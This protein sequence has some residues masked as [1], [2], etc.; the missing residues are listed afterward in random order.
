MVSFDLVIVGLANRVSHTQQ[1]A[2]TWTKDDLVTT[3][4]LGRIF[5]DVWNKDKQFSFSCFVGL[6]NRPPTEFKYL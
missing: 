4:H 3:A 6:S 5:G 1:E 2:I